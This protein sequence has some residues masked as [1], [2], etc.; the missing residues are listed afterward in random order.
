MKR[1]HT[2]TGN[3][4]MDS[5]EPSS[6]QRLMEDNLRP[7]DDEEGEERHG[8]DQNGGSLSNS[9]VEENNNKG[10][11]GKAMAAS[12]S[13]GSGTVRKYVGS[14]MTRLRWTPDLHLCF[15]RAVERLGGHDRATPKL[16]LRLMNIKGLSIAHVKSHLQMY[17][18][19]KIDDQNQ[20]MKEQGLLIETNDCH[21][22]HLS[23]LSMLRS[24]NNER[25]YSRYT[26][27]PWRSHDRHHQIYS[28]SCHMI[29]GSSLS[30]NYSPRLMI[31][32][33]VHQQASTFPAETLARPYMP[34]THLIRSP[35][36]TSDPPTITLAAR[37]REAL[38]RKRHDSNGLL[39]LD[40]SLRVKA[41]ADM[42]NC[43]QEGDDGAVGSNLLL[44]LNSFISMP[45][46]K[47][48]TLNGSS[49][50]YKEEEEGGEITIR[51]KRT[52]AL[53]LTL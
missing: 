27:S 28:P 24:L 9:T 17:R 19:K 7:G 52:S 29:G 43:E 10:S 20:A 36:N 2:S 35:S 40:L 8:T 41:K 46:C 26:S 22:Y 39:D 47:L 1:S 34:M 4:F 15:V 31:K 16:V 49:N 13:S 12:S 14:K 3:F 48:T 51:T 44:S 50:E 23:Q 42:M 5:G 53:D 37:T 45:S 25:A 11:S 38:K 32:S 33:E 6:A 21:I 18:S 30:R